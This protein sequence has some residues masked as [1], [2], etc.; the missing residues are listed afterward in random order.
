MSRFKELLKELLSK[1]VKRFRVERHVSQE[2]MA[3]TL[4]ISTRSYIDLE[5]AKYCFSSPSL[6]LFMLKLSDNEVLALLRDCRKL[7]EEIGHDDVA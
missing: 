4:H 1:W 7:K 3:E 2:V 6:I 5:H